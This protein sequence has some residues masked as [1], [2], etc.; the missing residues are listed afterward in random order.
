LRL[1][2]QGH[3][4]RVLGGG[5]LT[6]GRK[7]NQVQRGFRLRFNAKRPILLSL[8]LRTGVPN[9]RVDNAEA[10]SFGFVS[11]IKTVA[12]VRLKEAID[13]GAGRS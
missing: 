8:P 3:R 1:I 11:E 4:N 10:K 5:A 12:E 6:A 7:R 9:R 13:G 2:G